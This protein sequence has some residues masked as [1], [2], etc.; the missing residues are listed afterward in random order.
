MDPT[1]GAPVEGRTRGAT[2]IHESCMMADAWAT[3]LCVAPPCAAMRLAKRH[4]LAA[5]L[6]YRKSCGSLCEWLSPAM[7]AMTR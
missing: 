5:R 4:G 1:T 7:Q 6:I 3:A 2:V